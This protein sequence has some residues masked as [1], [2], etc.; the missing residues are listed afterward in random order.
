[1]EVHDVNGMVMDNGGCEVDMGIR[2]PD[3][4]PIEYEV[5]CSRILNI[6]SSLFFFFFFIISF[7]LFFSHERMLI[8]L[9]GAGQW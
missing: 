9:E 6:F 3:G 7:Y 1:M 2:S 8:S 4:E 5:C